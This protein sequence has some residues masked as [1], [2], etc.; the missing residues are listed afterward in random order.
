MHKNEI[1]QKHEEIIA[2]LNEQIEQLKNE[3]DEI[4]STKDKFINELKAENKKILDSLSKEIEDHKKQLQAI[5]QKED[6][7]AKVFE[8][9]HAAIKNYLLGLSALI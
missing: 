9:K 4:V 1:Q 6:L 2:Q 8:E 5:K 3:K 7:Q